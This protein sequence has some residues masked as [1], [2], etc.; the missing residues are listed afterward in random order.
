MAFDSALHGWAFAL[1][2]AL[3]EFGGVPIPGSIILA[4]IGAALTGAALPLAI[5]AATFGAVAA[6][7]FW[8]GVGRRRGTALVRTYC[9][10]TLGSRGCTERTARFFRRLGARAL[11]VAKFVPGLSAFAAPFAGLS[12]TSWR[13][14]W[15]TSWRRFW[16]W[17]VAG[18]F[19][20]SA[21]WLAAGHVLGREAL[22]RFE[23][24]ASM[25]Q[26]WAV[27]GLAVVVVGFV[28]MKILRRRRLGPAA[29][30]LLSSPAPIGSP[31]VGDPKTAARAPAS[32][33]A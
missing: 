26:H 10:V 15:L 23:A 22:V 25:A 32:S 6:D 27:A 33:T 17:D 2:A 8:F 31:S 1:L 30:E 12:G 3:L 13:R 9:K 4:G 16:L 18:A 28:A 29:P 5:V 7:T 20:W 24:S 14:F 21:T 11:V 19:A